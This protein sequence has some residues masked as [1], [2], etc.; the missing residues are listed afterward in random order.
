MHFNLLYLTLLLSTAYTT[1]GIAGRKR[2][3]SAAS[4]NAW[5]E[6]I[7]YKGSVSDSVD[8][9]L[10]EAFS[11]FAVTES[12]V[13]CMSSWVVYWQLCEIP[14][15]FNPLM[16]NMMVHAVCSYH[17]FDLGVVNNVSPGA[18]DSFP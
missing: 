9:G 5:A 8:P 16:L 14:K 4:R 12:C 17:F 7:L 11:C 15:P 13:A 2:R 18:V 10:P 6:G 1:C 3:L